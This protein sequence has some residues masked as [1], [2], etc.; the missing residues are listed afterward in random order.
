MDDR[1]NNCSPSMQGPCPAEVADSLDRERRLEQLG[2]SLS[3]LRIFLILA[4]QCYLLL[5]FALVYIR[6][7]SGAF[8]IAIIV[9]AVNTLL[10]AGCL[11]RFFSIRKAMLRLSNTSKHIVPESEQR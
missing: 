10:C 9:L 11:V 1:M 6:P 5:G 4:V 8:H 3:S 2:L 7:S